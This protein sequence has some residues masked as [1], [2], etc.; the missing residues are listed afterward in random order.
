MGKSEKGDSAFKNTLGAL[1]TYSVSS[2]RGCPQTFGHKMPALDGVEP[3]SSRSEEWA[4][5]V[6]CFVPQSHHIAHCSEVAPSFP[7][8]EKFNALSFS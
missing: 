1:T 8:L 6:L 7:A 4:A 3:S 5:C 2:S